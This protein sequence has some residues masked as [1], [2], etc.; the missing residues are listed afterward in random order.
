VER[1]IALEN[2]LEPFREILEENGYMVVH[3]PARDKEQIHAA[4]ISGLDKNV[5]NMQDISVSV[6]VINT[7]GLTPE[8]V[9]EEVERA[10]F[11]LE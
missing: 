1:I 8:E 10:A 2:G 7:D 5:M 11:H 3:F 4:V 9:L 6:P